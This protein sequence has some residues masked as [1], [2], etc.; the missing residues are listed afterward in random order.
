MNN[1]LSFEPVME[2]VK[3]RG[4]IQFSTQIEKRIEYKDEVNVWSQLEI[5][6]GLKIGTQFTNQVVGQ[7]WFQIEN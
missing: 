5:P 7:V 1:N 2:Q 3:E 6:V 4:I